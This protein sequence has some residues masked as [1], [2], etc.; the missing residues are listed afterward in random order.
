MGDWP[1][2]IFALVCGQDVLHTWAP[3]GVLLPCCQRCTGLYVGAAIALALHLGL[4][5]RAGSRFLQ[6]HGLFLLAMIPLGFHWIPQDAVARTVSGFLYGAGLVSFF[7]LLP[8]PALA[9][10]TPMSS[11]ALATYIV[12][13]GAG[14]AAV[15]ALGR[16]GGT[17]AAH[18]LVWLALLGLL[19]LALL[20]LANLG[21][22]AR[23][24]V[25]RALAGGSGVR[26]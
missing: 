21:L 2:A 26:S 17:G 5:I 12:V 18:A 3:G 22:A 25:G 9:R 20:A 10:L 11:P 1:R 4:R 24:I 23:W 14:A 15:P 6:V 7:W 19:G 8:G 13:V 16:L